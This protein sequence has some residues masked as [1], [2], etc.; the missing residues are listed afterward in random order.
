MRAAHRRNEI[1]V[2]TGIGFKMLA[3][4]VAALDLVEIMEQRPL[5]ER[6]KPAGELL[7]PHPIAGDAHR[8][9][10]A[11]CRLDGVDFRLRSVGNFATEVHRTCPFLACP[12]RWS[13]SV[14]WSVL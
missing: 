11:V 12:V 9:G 13:F 4:Q 7:E 8:E 6:M 14:F 3:Q 1:G 5:A 10:R 2:E